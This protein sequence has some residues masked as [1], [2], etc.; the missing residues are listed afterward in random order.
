MSEVI[1]VTSGKK[2]A[3]VRQQQ[4]PILALV[5]KQIGK[6]GCCYD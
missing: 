3:S 2:V 6:K 5:F 1:V 4:Q